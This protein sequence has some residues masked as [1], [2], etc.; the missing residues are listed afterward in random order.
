MKLS[1]CDPDRSVGGSKLLQLKTKRLLKPFATIAVKK[2][3][4]A[5]C[6]KHGANPV[7]RNKH[8]A[9]SKPIA[10]LETSFMPFVVR[11]K[12]TENFHKSIKTCIH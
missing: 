5:R 2:M 6:T 4:E 11:I 12:S 8:L 9:P 7:T 10:S 3:P 1:H